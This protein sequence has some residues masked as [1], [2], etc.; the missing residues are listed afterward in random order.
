MENKGKIHIGTSGWHYSH[1]SGVFYHEGMKEKEYLEYYSGFFDTVEINSSFYHLPLRTTFA[2]WKEITSENFIFSVKAS[3]YITHQKKLKDAAESVSLFLERTENLEEKLGMILFQLPPG[4]DFNRE[5]FAE[6]L[7][8]LPV[9]RKYAFEFRNH[10]WIND[11]VFQ[12]LSSHKMTF[13]VF[14]LEGYT[15]PKQ[16]T[17]NQVYVRLH[18][19][20]GA[21]Q[22]SYSEEALSEWANDLGEWSSRGIDVFC[23]F[24]NDQAGYAV[25]NAMRLSE[26][27]KA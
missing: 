10:G 3:R 8:K 1:W 16:V 20:G 25:K 18:G 17:S 26:I 7:E 2:R 27:L 23:Y 6:F 21:Y 19:P 14:D 24:N 22:G 12:L 9:G 4:W 11:S 15:T 5:S 13:C